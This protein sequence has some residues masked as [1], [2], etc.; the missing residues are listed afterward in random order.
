[1]NVLLPG[2]HLRVVARINSPCSH[3]MAGRGR[4]TMLNTMWMKVAHKRCFYQYRLRIWANR[5]QNGRNIFGS[6]ETVGN[7]GE[8]NHRRRFLVAGPAFP[9]RNDPT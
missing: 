9:V 1:V 8:P 7:F 2:A 4:I 6:A 3:G 5:Y